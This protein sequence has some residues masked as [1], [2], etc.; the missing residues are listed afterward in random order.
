MKLKIGVVPLCLVLLL[1]FL[2]PLS[3]EACSCAEQLS[4]SEALVN[5]EAVYRGEV[6][7]I[8]NNGKG[9]KTVFFNVNE[10]WKGVNETEVT[11][12]T[13]LDSSGCGI[14]FVV[15]KEYLVYANFSDM[16]G[17]QSLS[18]SLCDRTAEFDSG[19][20]DIAVLGQGEVPTEAPKIM[21]SKN[22]AFLIVGCIVFV[23]GLLGIYRWYRINRNTK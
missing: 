8:K 20:E 19:A 16:F 4:P 21:G 14:D 17:D 23:A 3:V 15:G 7:K 11:I 5:A 9:G 22:T 12:A 2:K 13:G 6:T 10:T 1:M 18:S